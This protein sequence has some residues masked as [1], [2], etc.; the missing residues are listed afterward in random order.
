MQLLPQLDDE[1]VRQVL[2]EPRSLCEGYLSRGCLGGP[3][4]EIIALNGDANY[5]VS[6]T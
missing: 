4:L 2:H 6:E 1:M 3:L 5:K